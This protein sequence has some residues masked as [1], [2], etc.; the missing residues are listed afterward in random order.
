M[1]EG[2][3]RNRKAGLTRNME[4]TD[5]SNRSK[6][7][8]LSPFYE[9]H[10]VTVHCHYILGTIFIRSSYSFTI[11][12]SF[13]I[14]LARSLLRFIF[15]GMRFIFFFNEFSCCFERQ[16]R[17]VVFEEILIKLPFIS[18]IFSPPILML[19]L[20]KQPTGNNYP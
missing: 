9:V 13:S 18:V 5:V 7:F 3:G 19:P 14:F 11:L 12:S 6:Y 1:V 10:Y 20:W 15:Y 17:F 8:P 16:V 2:V 4:E